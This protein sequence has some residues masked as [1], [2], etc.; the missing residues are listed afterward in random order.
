MKHI[1]LIMIVLLFTGYKGE[2]MNGARFVQNEKINLS[3]QKLQNLAS[4]KIYF[5]HQSVGSNIIDGIKDIMSIDDSGVKLNIKETRNPN[6]FDVPVF[7]HAGI[8]RNTEPI[9]KIDDFKKLMESGVGNKVDIAFFKFCYVDVNENTNLEEIFKY[10]T[11]TISILEAEYPKVK[12]V[13]CTVPL[14]MIQEGVK[15][16]IKKILGK[17]VGEEDNMKRDIF[18]RMLKEKYGNRVFD[19]AGAESTYPDGTKAEFG[20][21]NGKFAYLIPAYSDDGGHLNKL[22]K[23]IVAEELIKFLSNS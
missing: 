21:N 23:Q 4:K 20:K 17:S 9:S 12:F 18:N 16:G 10:Y 14:T 8:G 2:N 7:A 1:I 13:H 15:A 6:D 11:N 22:G 5:G 3:Q 19:L